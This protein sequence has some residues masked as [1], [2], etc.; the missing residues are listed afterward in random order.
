MIRML[1]GTP[2]VSRKG[3]SALALGAAVLALSGTPVLAQSDEG[4]QQMAQMQK[5]AEMDMAKPAPILVIYKE[6]VKAGRVT[7][8]DQLEANF[9]RTYAKLSGARNFIGMNSITGPNESWFVQPYASLE[10]VQKEYEAYDHAPS[11]IKTALQQISSGEN[12][13]LSMQKAITT[14]YR[15]DLSYKATM[16]NLPKMRFLQ[17]ITYRVAPGRD[18]D[19]VEAAKMVRA[20]YEKA[21]IPM[22]WACYQVW[23]GGPSNTYYVF[24]AV[25]SLA[26]IDPVANMSNMQAFDKALGEE[27]GKRLE[28]LVA[29]G[30][31]TQE[32][33]IYAFNPKTSYAPPAFAAADSFW[34]QP[35]QMAQVGTS[36]KAAG[37]KKPAASKTKVKK[38]Q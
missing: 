30:M 14:I 13:N 32:R 6:D 11:Q 19:F 8:H 38:Q 16:E 17:V 2:S 31:I 18:N 4:Q 29:D 25:D 20:T 27:G 21:N 36:G 37:A 33:N 10:D 15:E 23:S 5:P 22:Q 9:A 34:S 35:A 24:R 28:Q 26:K 3:L 1:H 12:D 7:S